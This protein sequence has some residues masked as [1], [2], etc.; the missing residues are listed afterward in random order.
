MSL[1]VHKMRR[2]VP[3]KIISITQTDYA[4]SVANP[5]WTFSNLAVGAAPTG[6]GARRFV[7]VVAHI[8]DVSGVTLVAPTIDGTTATLA[9]AL[10]Q[11][12]QAHIWIGYRERATGTTV[13]V[14]LDSIGTSDE[15]GVSVYSVITGPDGLSV[16]AT[17]TDGSINYSMSVTGSINGALLAGSSLRNG[18]SHSWGG[19]GGIVEDYDNEVAIANYSGAS[20]L[21]D[22]AGAKAVTCTISSANTAAGALVSL[23]YGT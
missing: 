2:S 8:T 5:A 21:L 11:A 1:A 6:G 23:K 22:S 16:E 4:G 3:A 14:I 18:T 12:S 15:G 19:A 10:S 20:A 13:D 17:D 7:F 9:V